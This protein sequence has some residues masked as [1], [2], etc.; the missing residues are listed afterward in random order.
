M[1]A[2]TTLGSVIKTHQEL[3][4]SQKYPI[5]PQLMDVSRQHAGGADSSIFPSLL[6]QRQ[7]VRQKLRSCTKRNSVVRQGQKETSLK[8]E[9]EGE[10]EGEGERERERE[11]ERHWEQSTFRQFFSCERHYC[12]DRSVADDTPFFR[13]NDISQEVWDCRL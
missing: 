8:G 10:G 4:P 11:R 3:C 13:G 1:L 6:I 2:L 9:R 12:F 7:C 5:N